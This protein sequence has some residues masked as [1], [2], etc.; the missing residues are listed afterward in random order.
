MCGIRLQIRIALID[1]EGIAGIG[2]VY[3]VGDI[4]CEVPDGVSKIDTLSL[5]G[6]VS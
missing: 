5:N 2:A 6:V 3:E 1:V 4:G